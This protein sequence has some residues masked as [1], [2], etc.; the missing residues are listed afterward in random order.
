MVDHD[1]VDLSPKEV[2]SRIVNA[3]AP[4]IE[5]EAGTSVAGRR[6]ASSAEQY[7]VGK[8][9][10]AGA[11]IGNRSETGECISVNDSENLF[12]HQHG[13]F[14]GLSISIHSYRAG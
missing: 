2:T 10:D 6:T 12:C 7:A 8:D 13:Q 11:V 9:A 14:F 3:A 1:L 5:I 4:N